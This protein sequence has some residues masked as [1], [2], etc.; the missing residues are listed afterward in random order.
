[1]TS[2]RLATFLTTHFHTSPHLARAALR[3]L[4]APPLHT[5]LFTTP[6]AQTLA[7]EREE[8]TTLFATEKQNLFFDPTLDAV[9]WAR[10]LRRCAPPPTLA[11]KLGAWVADA[12]RVLVATSEG[13]GGAALGWS[14]KTE[15]FTLGM[16]V[17]CAAEVALGWEVRDAVDIRQLL[18]RFVVVGREKGIGE[19]WV[20]VA[21]KVF[22]ESVLGVV[23]SAVGRVRAIE[24][25]LE[26]EEKETKEQKGNVDE[27][28]VLNFLKGLGARV[29]ATE[30]GLMKKAGM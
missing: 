15:V 25:G 18:G 19:L 12:L 28:R 5:P 26:Q 6:F 20:G 13:E 16:R 14:S 23:R 4:T 9:F 21:E 11:D 3:R 30:G 17:L 24:R 29:R 10:V 22:A 7:K 27:E 1:L 8:D 2:H